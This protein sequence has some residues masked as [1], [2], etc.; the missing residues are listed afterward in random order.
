M[1]TLNCDF[2][3][4]VGP[5]KPMHG[6]NNGPI[7]SYYNFDNFHYLTEAGI[8]FSRLHDTGGTFGGAR[9]VDIWNIFTDKDADEN[10]PASYDFT[11]TDLLI[12]NLKNAGVEPFYRLGTTIENG[13]KIKAYN[14]YPPE[15]YEKFARICAN[16]IRH[17]NY[18]WADGFHYDIKYWEIWNEPD[19]SDEVDEN[20]CWKGTKEQFFELYRVVSNHLRKEFPDIKIGGYA[21]CG[22]Y[23]CM[24]GEASAEE[25]KNANVSPRYKYFVTF[26]NEFMDYINAPETKSPMDFFTWHTYSAGPRAFIQAEYVRKQLD[27]RGMNHVESILDEWNPQFMRHGNTEHMVDIAHVMV[28]LHR[29]VDQL[30]FYTADYLSYGALFDYYTRKPTKAYYVFPAFNELYK[31]G[32]AVDVKT[33]NVNCPA[34]GATDGKANAIM[35][36]NATAEAQTVSL[37]GTPFKGAKGTVLLNDEEHTAEEMEYEFECSFELGP[38]SVVVIK[39]L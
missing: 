17:Y 2:S 35:F 38:K 23:A 29:Y 19:N 34:L 21:S 14:I 9:F 16:I 22:F 11:F 1:I 8:P 30:D 10:D 13:H 36:V 15:N 31:L 32:Q 3:N 25:I 39:T 5:V 33:G 18:G 27:S 26:F 6:V 4:P 20:P 7:A 12:T 28:L 24:S 37:D